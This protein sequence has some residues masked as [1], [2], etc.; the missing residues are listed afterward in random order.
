VA[1]VPS[2]TS[3]LTVPAAIRPSSTS[4]LRVDN[5]RDGCGSIPHPFSQAGS[6]SVVDS[7]GPVAGAT[8]G[9]KTKMSASAASDSVACHVRTPPAAT[10]DVGVA[11]YRVE[12]CAGVGCT[13]FVQIKQQTGR[14]F[15]NTGLAAS[16]SYSYRVYAY[17]NAGN[18][19]ASPTNTATATTSADAIAPSAPTSLKATASSPFNVSLTWTASTD[20]G[21][22]GLAGYK[23]E[24]CT[25]AS[26]TSF[27]Q[28]GTSA[29]NSYSDTTVTSSTTYVY[30]VRAY[31]NASSA[32]QSSYSS[33]VSATTPTDTTK[34]T[35]P[36]SLSASVQ[37]SSSIK[38]TWTAST[39]SGGNLAGYKVER[40]TGASCTSFA[41]LQTVTGASTLTYTDT[42]ALALTTYVYRVYAY[43]SA[44]NIS[45]Y[46]PSAGGTTTADTQS[47]SNP[48]VSV[49]VVSSTQLTVN[50][51]GS[52]DT[53]GSGLAGF[54]IARC[55][56]AGCTSFSV[57]TTVSG[58]ATSYADSNLKSSTTYVYRARAFDGA[59]PANYSSGATAQ[60]AT[61]K[62]TVK[63]STPTNFHTTAVA[64]HRVDFAWT[65]ATDT[66]G[67]G[68][69]SYVIE[70]CSGSCTTYATVS[71]V[72]GGSSTSGYDATAADYTTYGYRMYAIDGDGNTSDPSTTISVSTPDVTPPSVTS[73]T[74][75]PINGTSA[76]ATWSASDAGGSGVTG[77][78]YR[79]VRSDGVTII[80][81]TAT[82][83]TT[84]ALAGLACYTSY[85][86][87][88]LARDNANNMTAESSYGFRTPDTCPP[89][90]PGA[91]S[92]S[93]VNYQSVV[94]SWGA[95]TDNENRLSG[96]QYSLDGGQ[97]WTTV[98][99]ATSV[100]ISGLA[101]AT[102]YTV[103]VR[104]YDID[105]NVSASS[106]IGS[107]TTMSPSI[108][109]PASYF[110][111]ARG[112]A[113]FYL[114]A[115]GRLW[116]NMS[117]GVGTYFG[118]WMTP[119]VPS[120]VYEVYATPS[121]SV[122][123]NGQMYKWVNLSRDLSWYA[124]ARG[125]VT[126]SCT[127]S[128][129]IRRVGTTT[130]LASGSISASSTP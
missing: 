110:F 38:L 8:N 114:Q 36:S 56:G 65:S 98:G 88:V 29:T 103:V 46:S 16:T 30:R 130:V 14:T 129:Q 48:S 82:A 78:S 128:L 47:P 24:R 12:R 33:S 112:A 41:A 55:Q 60:G 119:S 96:Y 3:P 80:G 62:D 74:V 72:T 113:Q 34:P 116:N 40:C 99:S 87:Y 95:A 57:L 9:P 71:N 20:T 92:F 115:D 117:G 11:G 52:T 89:G 111:S 2:V 43:D 107:F 44:G 15:A 19:S 100:T 84:A 22:A 102:S 124:L 17:D 23:I 108:S 90:A 76:T 66:G 104:A 59:S 37:S 106:A 18:I 50:F 61:S 81:S 73:V 94:A 86:F 51:S 123:C 58:S 6:T 120:N 5:G 91:P 63:P 13:D 31:D 28:I 1:T 4:W 10:D 75:T 21:G 83:S 69:M 25:G 93:S 122:N 127:M 70:R 85:T 77:Y 64:G 45:G 101:P 53:G 35:T 118:S 68:V 121:S 49:S 27:S 97:N 79:L 54:E 126:V 32:N 7:S 26:C 39:D 42:A 125:S 105:L 67:S 109:L